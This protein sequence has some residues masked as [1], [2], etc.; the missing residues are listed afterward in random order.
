MKVR[1][2]LGIFAFGSL[3]ACMVPDVTKK[4]DLCENNSCS[5]NPNAST[6]GGDP[7][8]SGG[9]LN[10]TTGAP[11]GVGEST[12]ADTA[13]AKPQDAGTPTDSTPFTPPPA[14]D[15]D[16]G[17]TDPVTADAPSCDKLLDCCAALRSA[18]NSTDADACDTTWLNNDDTSCFLAQ[19]DYANPTDGTTGTC[20]QP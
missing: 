17:T 6:S 16:A 14:T 18:G 1:Y 12:Q 19:Y 10:A 15:T 3:V 20:V 13:P 8:A 11:I 5:T 9:N 7:V 2:L 4:S